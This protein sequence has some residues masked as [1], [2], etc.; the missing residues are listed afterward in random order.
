MQGACPHWLNDEVKMSGTMRPET[1]VDLIGRTQRGDTRTGPPEER[2]KLIGFLVR[3]V[4]EMHDM[5]GRFENQRSDTERTHAMLY[6]PPRR[7]VDET[8]RKRSSTLGKVTGD[9]ANSAHRPDR[10][11]DP[12][13]PAAPAPSD[14]ARQRGFAVRGSGQVWLACCRRWARANTAT[15]ARRRIEATANHRHGF[16]LS[17]QLPSLAITL[18]IVPGP[19][20][21]R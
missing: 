9:A 13:A 5:P 20:R 17:V 10:R 15:P 14:P 3:K 16:P 11:D 1:R 2:A 21:F 7:C 18:Q 19:S 4:G 8:S 12:T 6:P